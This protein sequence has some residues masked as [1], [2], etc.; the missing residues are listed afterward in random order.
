MDLGKF[1]KV[2]CSE[3]GKDVFDIKAFKFHFQIIPPENM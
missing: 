2:V 3:K 1:G